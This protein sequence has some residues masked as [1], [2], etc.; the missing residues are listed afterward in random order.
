MFN[1]NSTCITSLFWSNKKQPITGLFEEEG[2]NKKS[3]RGVG[4]VGLAYSL[5]VFEVHAVQ[6]GN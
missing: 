5:I 3:R 2:R 4:S 1:E 6:P